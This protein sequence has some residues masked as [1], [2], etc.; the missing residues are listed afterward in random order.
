MLLSVSAL[1]LAVLPT[2][3]APATQSPSP[4]HEAR[5]VLLR[6]FR[7]RRDFST[8]A[9]K[10]VRRHFVLEDPNLL[11]RADNGS[12]THFNSSGP[13]PQRGTN[14][15]PFYHPSNTALDLQNPDNV[16]PPPT[17]NGVVPNL[18]WVRDQGD[19]SLRSMLMSPVVLAVAYPLAQRRLGPRADHHRPSAALPLSLTVRDLPSSTEFAAAELTLTPGSYRELHWHR[20]DEWAVVLSG[21]GRI[22]AID[23]DGRTS[24]DDVQTGDLWCASGP[25]RTL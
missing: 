23:S 10:H 3:A 9:S 22:A 21:S 4:A 18:K 15:G 12:I 14:G 17:D 7:E 6:G 2:L 25:A 19:A 11:K 1:L 20:V 13:V 16:S 24:V 5:D 8:D